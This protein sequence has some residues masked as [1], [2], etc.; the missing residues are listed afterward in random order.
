MVFTSRSTMSMLFFSSFLSSII[1]AFFHGFNFLTIIL[2]PSSSTI[3]STRSM[4]KKFMKKD[5]CIKSLPRIFGMFFTMSSMSLLGFSAFLASFYP[6]GIFLV[7]VVFFHGF[8]FFLTIIL[9]PTS[10]SAFL[11]SS[12]MSKTVLLQES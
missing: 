2:M 8:V 9:V 3:L 7:V 4:T 6:F 12:D 5:K 1:V 11:S 10:I